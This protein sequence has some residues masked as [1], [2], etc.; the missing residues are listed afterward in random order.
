MRR[1]VWPPALWGGARG[2]GSIGAPGRGVSALAKVVGGEGRRKGEGARP[3]RRRNCCARG[4]AVLLPPLQFA[5]AGAAATAEV[6]A[7]ARRDAALPAPR[8]TVPGLRLL[9]APLRLQPARRVPGGRCG[10]RWRE[11]AGRSGFLARGRRARRRKRGGQR[12]PGGASRPV[13]QVRAVPCRGAGARGAE[14]RVSIW[15][16][17][18]E[19]PSRAS[20]HRARVSRFFAADSDPLC[21]FPSFPSPW[22]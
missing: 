1:R 14:S 7:R 21:S 5:R 8:G 22:G 6:A 13:G 18:H 4:C 17:L 9:L 10:R 2:G 16:G 19:G 15:P 12:G 3:Q 20:R 11:A